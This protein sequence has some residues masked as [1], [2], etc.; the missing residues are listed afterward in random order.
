MSSASPP[1]P[2]PCA[3]V[4]RAALPESPTSSSFSRWSNSGS[5]CM[6]LRRVAGLPLEI[7]T[8]ARASP[9]PRLSARS[10]IGLSLPL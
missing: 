9:C 2:P 1:S 5:C 8:R 3:Q 6:T 10:G 4:T 7:S